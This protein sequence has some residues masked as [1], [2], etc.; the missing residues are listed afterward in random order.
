MRDVWTAQAAV[1]GLQRAKGLP[2][3]GWSKSVIQKLMVLQDVSSLG[4]LRFYRSICLG[5]HK[6][7]M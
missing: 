5:N 7:Q 2:E 1:L 4:S 6:P 3:D